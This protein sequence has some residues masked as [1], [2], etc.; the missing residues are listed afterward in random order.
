MAKTSTPTRIDV[1]VNS[2][3]GARTSLS[4]APEWDFEAVMT[5]VFL[6]RGLPH[7]RAHIYHGTEELKPGMLL[8][9]VGVQNGSELSFVA[10]PSR[11]VAT[12]SA[13]SSS[14][15]KAL[16]AKFIHSRNTSNNI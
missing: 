14:D 3:G 9:D 11:L 12:A 10:L 13:S 7:S 4:V 1:L 5:A 15:C 8:E 6:A 2:I 16:R